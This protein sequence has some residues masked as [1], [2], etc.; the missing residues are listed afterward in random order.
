MRFKKKVFATQSCPVCSKAFQII[1]LSRNT[2]EE[3]ITDLAANL[4]DQIK[5]K[6]SSFERFSIAYDEYD[7]SMDICGIIELAVFLRACYKDFTIFEELLELIP[8]HGSTAGY[9]IF[10]TVL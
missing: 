5:A 3:R 9:D 8:M 7:E 4:S 1:P 6:S 10:N 2:V